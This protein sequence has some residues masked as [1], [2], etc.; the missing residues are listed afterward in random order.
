MTEN[1]I[2]ARVVRR[3]DELLEIAL[4]RGLSVKFPE[5]KYDLTGRA[6]GTAEICGIDCT[7]N[8]NLGILTNPKNTDEFIKQTVAHEVAHIIAWLNYGIDI[9]P[10]GKEWRNIMLGFGL[11]PHRT[12]KYD[13]STAK[14]R[15]QRRYE[16]VCTGCGKVLMISATRHNRMK[17]G[18]KYRHT[19]G[20]LIL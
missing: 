5:I 7:L 10:H 6:A 9:Q 17:R 1:E 15:R 3:I 20:G 4:D 14:V 13:M 8:F 2:K 16:H 12:H 18:T 11:Y 19:C